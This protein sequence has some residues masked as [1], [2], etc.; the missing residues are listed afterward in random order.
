MDRESVA[1]DGTLTEQADGHGRQN[2]LS[3][4]SRREVLG[5][6]VTFPLGNGNSALSRDRLN[7]SRHVS[8]DQPG[9]GTLT[10]RLAAQGSSMLNDMRS[11]SGSAMPG[12]LPVRFG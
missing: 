1:L 6:S 2:A 9:G 10:K 11:S 4:A 5:R 7:V 3:G 12:C 8:R